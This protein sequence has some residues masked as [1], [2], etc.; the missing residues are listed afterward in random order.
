FWWRGHSPETLLPYDTGTVP[1]A[2]AV[3]ATGL[4]NIGNITCHYWLDGTTSFGQTSAGANGLNLV[5]N[6]YP[7][8]ID[9]TTINSGGII[10]SNISTQ[11]SEL[12]PATGSYGNYDQST[13]G[14]NGA[15]QYIVSG[16]GFFITATASGATL[17]FT[18]NAKVNHQLVNGD[19][20]TPLLLSKSPIA[21][22]GHPHV[23]LEMNADALHAEDVLFWFDPANKT[24]FEPGKDARYRLGFNTVSLSSLST[25]GIQLGIDKQPLPGKDRRVIGLNVDATS[26]GTYHFNLREVAAIPQLYNIWLVD[27]QKKDSVN[28]RVKNTYDFT[29]SKG[30]NTSFGDQRFSLVIE[31][32]PA[33]AYKLLDFTASKLQ[34]VRQVQTVW[35]TRNEENY[36]NFTVERSTDGGKT[37]DVL[38]AVKAA[39][40]GNYSFIDKSP[41]SGTNLY[42]LKQEDI[43]NAISY[44]K[45]V[46]VEYS[47]KGDDLVNSKISIYPN[48]ATGN[49]NVSVKDESAGAAAYKIRIVSTMGTVV[50]EVASPQ[51]GWQGN[52]SSLLPG[53][54]MVRIFNSK[55]QDMV[56]EGKFVKL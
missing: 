52:V 51:P 36:T 20:N 8:T 15:S 3:Q 22:A 42:R 24:N 14:T 45:V 23:R 34:T 48:P 29:I 35:K 40:N 7:S 28:L 43:N 39:G 38:G 25:D 16:Q 1:V 18:E 12:N 53:T 46:P 55:T 11:I 41:L 54:Y 27:A 2:G 44:S 4:L 26:D 19:P 30:D 49:I 6:P 47:D 56:A 31:Q 21:D 33:L 37:F 50:K 17:T 9:W 32:N 5:G 10:T 13:G